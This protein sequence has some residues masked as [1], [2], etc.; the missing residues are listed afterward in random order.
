[1]RK[2]YRE[3]KKIIEREGGE[4]INIEK[5]DRMD[6]VTITFGGKEVKY[7]FSTSKHCNFENMVKSQIKNLKRT[8]A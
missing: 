2:E 6:K 3:L 1:M 7:N 4:I 8:A 5:H